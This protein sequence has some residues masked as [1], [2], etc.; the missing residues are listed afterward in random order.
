[1]FE[2]IILRYD[3]SGKFQKE[4]DFLKERKKIAIF[5]YKQIKHLGT[6]D[7]GYDMEKNLP[8]VVHKNRNLYFSRLWTK[9]EALWK[10][11]DFIENENILGGDY[12]ENAPHRYQSESFH[13]ESGDTLLDVGCAEALFTLDVIDL[14]KKAILFESDP[15]WFEPLKATFEKEMKEGKVI[16]IEKNAGEK[17]TS[18]SVTID[19]V[20]KNEEYES[21]FIKMDI[22]GN[23]TKVV[24]SCIDLMRSD[25]DICFS[26]CTYHKQND[27]VILKDIFES[28]GYN[29]TFSDGYMLFLHDR[30]IRYPYFRKGIIRA[31]KQINR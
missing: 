22:E 30:L 27:A 5:P 13:V 16:L 21:L 2:A 3:G 15:N 28:N 31:T 25:K 12:T 6:V 17:N 29:T 11:K 4:I 20:L 1:L 23:E 8:Y 10:Y 19:S 24:K 9:E 14:V 18:Q 26:C 7:Y